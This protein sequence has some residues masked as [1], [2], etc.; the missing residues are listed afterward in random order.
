[1]TATITRPTDAQARAIIAGIDNGGR[2][3]SDPYQLRT[4]T[5][6]IREGWMTEPDGRTLE[7]T[8]AGRAAVAP[9][10]T[11]RAKAAEVIAEIE[12]ETAAALDENRQAIDETYARLD[13]EREAAAP[14]EPRTPRGRWAAGLPPQHTPESAAGLREAAADFREQAARDQ[15]DQ[16]APPAAPAARTL[17]DTTPRQEKPAMLPEIPVTLLDLDAAV[18]RYSDA[19]YGPAAREAVS[20]AA[21]TEVADLATRATLGHQVAELLA[22][23]ADRRAAGVPAGEVL[24]EVADALSRLAG[25]PADEPEQATAELHYPDDTAPFTAVTIHAPGQ[26]PQRIEIPARVHGCCPFGAE[27]GNGCRLGPHRLGSVLAS[28]GYRDADRDP[29][30]R[31]K[32]IPL[33]AIA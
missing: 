27:G 29:R 16:P 20:R 15:A 17:P 10:L 13:Q 26:Q 32:T 23:I 31:A 33:E 4:I 5:A 19:T 24:D 3:S 2:T 7:V 14:V 1:M 18:N 11:G 21:A 30:P 9:K 22:A 12:R 8:D 25:V 6:L 28:A